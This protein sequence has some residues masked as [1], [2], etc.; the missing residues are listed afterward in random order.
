LSVL[1]SANKSWDHK[2]ASFHLPP[3]T[4]LMLADVNAGSD[5]PSLV[6]KVLKWRSEHPVEG[7]GSPMSFRNYFQ[8]TDHGILSAREL[9]DSL[10]GTNERFATAL[11]AMNEAHS[12]SP[13]N[14][15]S[16]LRAYARLSRRDV[17][18]SFF[19]YSPFWK[20]DCSPR[21][22]NTSVPV[23]SRAHDHGTRRCAGHPCQDA[24]HGR[25]IWSAHR[26]S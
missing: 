25:A 6:G 4:R 21:L 2:V 16:A 13:L 1:S 17:R 18:I 7:L 12:R 23:V 11:G 9:W 26:A 15:Q 20:A 14:Y 5:T 22:M 3:Y 24:S 19:V 8:S 10:A